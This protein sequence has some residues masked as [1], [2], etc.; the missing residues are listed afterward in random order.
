MSINLHCNKIR[1][2][3]TPTH[4]TYMCLVPEDPV[5]ALKMYTIWVESTTSGV[6]ENL[7]AL[8]LARDNVHSHIDEVNKIINDPPKDLEVYTL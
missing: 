5:T 1:L 8:M 2:W 4:I 7:D 6:W 3:Q